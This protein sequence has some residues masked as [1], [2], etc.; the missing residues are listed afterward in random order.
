[1]MMMMVAECRCPRE[2]CDGELRIQR[3]AGNR[4]FPVTHFWR[5]SDDGAGT[6]YFEAKGSHDHPAP[7]QRWTRNGLVSDTTQI[8]APSR[9]TT[10]VTDNDILHA[11]Y[12]TEG[13]IYKTSY[14]KFS[15]KI[16]VKSSSE[17]NKF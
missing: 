12:E 9:T 14:N 4:G 1:M 7:D 6:I 2:G 16:F 3:C 10:Q 8:T 13:L 17:V 5:R 11:M 15:P